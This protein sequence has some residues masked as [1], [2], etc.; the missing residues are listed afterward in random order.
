MAMPCRGLAQPRGTD[1]VHIIAAATPSL[2]LWPQLQSSPVSSRDAV[3]QVKPRI[4]T[5]LNPSGALTATAGASGLLHSAA[6]AL[7]DEEIRP[8]QHLGMLL[9]QR[10]ALTLSHTAPDAELDPVVERVGPT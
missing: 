1:Q 4:A 2:T 10:A 6:S 7:L 5:V 3:A 8:R 9:E